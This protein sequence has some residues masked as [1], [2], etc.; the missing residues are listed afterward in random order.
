[1]MRYIDMDE[2]PAK[3]PV[4]WQAK[5]D[6]AL[7]GLRAEIE[8]AESAAIAGGDDRVAAR[9]AAIRAGLSKAEREEVWKAI[10]PMLKDL[11]DRKCWYS[12]SRN[13]TADKNVDH[14]R[15]KGRVEEDPLHEG[16]WWL[17]GC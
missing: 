8:E 14:F 7:N 4:G 16:Y 13:P 9:K 3:L 15:P 1:V 12:E 5:A 11:G 17:A 2:V 6:A 10:A